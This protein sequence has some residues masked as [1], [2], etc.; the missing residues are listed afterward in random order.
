MVM[1]HKDAV[2]LRPLLPGDVDAYVLEQRVEITA[3]AEILDA[4]LRRALTETT[5]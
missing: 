5:R 2:K 1:T 4:A 3:G